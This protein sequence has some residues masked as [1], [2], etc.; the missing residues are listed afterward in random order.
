MHS[1]D[2]VCYNNMFCVLKIINQKS[3]PK[4]ELANYHLD[5]QVALRNEWGWDSTGK[6]VFIDPYFRLPFMK[7]YS[8]K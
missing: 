2:Y 3:T 1:N 8:I 6:L 5:G 7:K 4:Y